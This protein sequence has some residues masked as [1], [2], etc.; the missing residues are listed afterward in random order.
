M[1]FDYAKEPGKTYECK[2]VTNKCEAKVTIVTAYYNA[3]KY[4]Q[5]TF[6]SIVNQT[7]PHFEWL[8]V[9]DGSKQEQ[10]D[11]V[12]KLS[13]KDDR[14]RVIDKENGGAAS[15][16]NV[17]INQAKSDYIM[18]IDADDL[19]EKTHLENLYITMMFN[20]EIDWVTSDS[21]GFGEKEY[22]WK[23]YITSDLEKIE[24]LFVVNSL[25]KKSALLGI[26]GYR[27]KPKTFNED[28]Y[29]YL[30]LL[31]N[32]YIPAKISTYGFWYRNLC[33]GNLRRCL[34]DNEFSRQ[35]KLIIE[36]KAKSVPNGIVTIGF[37]GRFREEFAGIE[38]IEFDTKLPY[39]KEKINVL[40]MIP[41]MVT[42]G[43]DKFN[44]DFVKNIDR[45]KFRVGIITTTCDENTLLQEFA[46]YVDDIFELHNFL[47]GNQWV[48][49]VEYYIRTRNVKIL[50]NVS[51]Y[52]SYY[53]MPS[54]SMKFPELAIVD[55]IH[56]D[57]Q[58]WRSGGYTRTSAAFDEL[59]EKTIVANKETLEIMC[60]KYN[61]DRAKCE[62]SYIGVDEKVFDAKQYE[63]GKIRKTYNID[64]N[65][66][67]VLF[68][69]R[70]SQE[71]R[72]ILLLRIV[73]EIKKIIPDICFLI[74]GDGDCRN[75][76][77]LFIEQHHL[78]DNVVMAGNQSVVAPYYKD[79]DL[80]L[81]T[82]I[83]EG[84]TLT[85]FEAMSMGIPVIS[86]DV[87]SQYEVVNDSTGALIPLLQD[88]VED[89][90][91]E[92]YSEEEVNSYVKKI[93]EFLKDE[94]KRKDVGTYNRN[95]IEKKY[96]M[97]I[98]I[99]RIE[100]IFLELISDTA[101]KNRIES[102]K[103]DFPLLFE[104][105]ATTYTSYENLVGY[106]NSL[107]AALQDKSLVNSLEEERNQARNEIDV[108]KS[109]LEK[110][111]AELERIESMRTWKLV[112]RYRNFMDN[113]FIGRGLR[114]IFRL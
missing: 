25:F 42:G 76:M 49:F 56:A 7:F 98:S 9:N 26:G 10:A 83:K 61:K 89:F 40:L 105:V 114:K 47:V 5:Q 71:K 28:W 95:I 72:P 112:Q 16:R 73:E 69:A 100:E 106:A 19:I 41:H 113:T 22:L 44:L 45:D 108:L 102:R 81:I 4:I 43:A 62:I 35:N 11:F 1:G 87:G 79:A 67:I 75:K 59:I 86:S 84:L 97:Y 110:Y 52:F 2:Y 3:S 82:S 66:F 109:E 18:I 33:D 63:Y 77:E 38:R 30:D 51:S 80:M 48:G 55:Y 58:Y 57:A 68:L 36:E 37:D 94:Q 78:E 74:V 13:M 50:F 101:V 93:C 20:P 111:S 107:Y 8:I 6:N 99:R 34:D 32:G 88:E 14:V 39:K 23:R 15:A 29:L 21:V 91:N 92:D 12:K 104:E 90:N 64:E 24:N 70:L 96:S 27:E 17:G 65:R 60:K 103:N 53:M 54:L 85:T 46:Q 31:A